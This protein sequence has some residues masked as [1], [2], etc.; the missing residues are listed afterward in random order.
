M[1]TDA[2]KK[3]REKSEKN[4][5]KTQQHIPVY[6]PENDESEKNTTWEGE[7]VLAEDQQ[8]IYQKALRI[9]NESGVKYAVGASFARHAYTSIWR[10]TKDLDVFIKP[11][12]LW[13]VMN[14]FKSA[15]FK[16]EIRE[17]HWLAKAW[18]KD[19]FI[20]LIFGQGHGLFSINDDVFEGSKQGEVLGEWTYLIPIE[21]SSCC[22]I[23]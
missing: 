4:E 11:E 13:T 12:D 2:E 8:A 6:V 10:P 15:G 19:Y 3:K 16:T 7:P 14:A 22:S 9:L 20:D 1:R 18:K 21:D 17:E 5:N 23:I